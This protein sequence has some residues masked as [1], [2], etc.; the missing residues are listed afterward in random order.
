MIYEYI[1]SESELGD[2]EY[3]I[4]IQMTK[5][6]NEKVLVN[7]KSYIDYYKKESDYADQ[8]FYFQ[9]VVGEQGEKLANCIV[10]T[11]LKVKEKH[12]LI[13]MKF[14]EADIDMALG[15]ANRF[16]FSN[17]V[18]KLKDKQLVELPR[19]ESRVNIQVEYKKTTRFLNKDNNS[20]QMKKG[21]LRLLEHNYYLNEKCD[22][23]FTLRMGTL[24]T[25]I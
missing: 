17:Y 4:G 12:H 21:C 13:V 3:T 23:L 5:L 16:L 6:I 10:E 2:L 9:E 24:Y 22:G 20:K 11:T 14:N 15:D 18:H 25:K 8:L 19:L 1:N 7:G